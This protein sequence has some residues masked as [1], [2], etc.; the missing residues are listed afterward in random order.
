MEF[1]SKLNE[2]GAKMSGTYFRLLD[3]MHRPFIQSG[4]DDP[5]HVTFKE[6]ISIGTK[7]SSPSILEIGSRDVTGITRKHL[8]PMCDK[9]IGFDIHEGNGVD[10]VGDVH[11]L[12]TYFPRNHFDLVYTMAVFEHLLFPW[13]VALEI[14]RVIKA[15]GYV[16]VGT[17]STWPTHELPWDFWRYQSNGFHALFNKYSGFEIVNISEGLPCKAYSLVDDIPTRGICQHTLNQGVSMIARKIG[18]YREDL[19]RWDIDISD[20]LLTMYPN[21]KSK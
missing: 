3:M 10:V 7:L 2:I 20:V 5:Y 4:A 9:Y 17:V 19:L 11:K 13:K 1:I 12:S 21:N 6:F 16:F 8:F 15:G 18:D 14:N